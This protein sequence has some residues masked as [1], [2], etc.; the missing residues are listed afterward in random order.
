SSGEP[1]LARVRP[2]DVLISAGEGNRFGF[3]HPAVLERCRKLGAAVLRTDLHGAIECS[4]DGKR[5]LF[6]TASGLS[7]RH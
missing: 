2:A 4:T 3:P 7:I 5:T 6:R 1:F